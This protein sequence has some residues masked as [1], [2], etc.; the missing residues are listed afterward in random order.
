MASKELERL[1]VKKMLEDLSW[2]G[3]TITPGDEPPDLFLV[4]GESRL[5]V[6]VTRI[7]SREGRKGSA[8]AADEQAFQQF[9]SRLEATYFQSAGAP[10]IQVTVAFPPIIRSRSVRRFSRAE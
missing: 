8:E 1:F 10:S 9:V 4:K 2:S 3:M 6:E 5:A 7:Y